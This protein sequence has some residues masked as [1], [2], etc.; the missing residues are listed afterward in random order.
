MSHNVCVFV[1]I[2][3]ECAYPNLAGREFTAKTYRWLNI[4]MSG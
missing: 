3:E 1:V 4:G 2:I